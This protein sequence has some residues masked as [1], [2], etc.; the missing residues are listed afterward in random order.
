MAEDYVRVELDPPR[1]LPTELEE[2]MSREDWFLLGATMAFLIRGDTV[3]NAV[4][5]ARKVVQKLEQE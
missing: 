1:T 3:S 5:G 2:G 4:W